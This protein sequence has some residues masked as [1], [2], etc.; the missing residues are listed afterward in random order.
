MIFAPSLHAN[1][2][3]T[4]RLCFFAQK[5]GSVGLMVIIRTVT[6]AEADDKPSAKEKKQTDETLRESV[7]SYTFLC[8]KKKRVTAAWRVSR[9]V[10]DTVLAG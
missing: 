10:L 8:G 5:L 7:M 3:F 1:Y 9:G 4:F 2:F 6:L